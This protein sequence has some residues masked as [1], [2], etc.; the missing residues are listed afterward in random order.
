MGGFEI[1]QHTADMG[2][3]VWGE[4]WITLFEEAARGMVSLIV[5][6]NSVLEKEKRELLI[7]GEN[8]EELLLKWLRE[9]LF[10][11]EGGMVFASF[12]IRED[13][14]YCK[15]IN[16]YK[17]IGLLSGEKC[18]PSRHDICTEIKA[19]TRHG[20]LLKKKGPWWETSILFDV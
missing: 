20:L 15:D 1:I 13:N 9:I 11:V 10:L 7:E 2:I 6:F 19:V 17:F 8:G 18:D 3:R 16:N 4:D 12:H 5:D 14:F